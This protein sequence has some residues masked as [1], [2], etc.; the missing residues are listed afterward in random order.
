[1]TLLA[2]CDA[3]VCTRSRFSLYARVLTDDFGGNVVRLEHLY[4]RL[5]ATGS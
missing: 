1:M 4:R 3:L 5:V 2:R